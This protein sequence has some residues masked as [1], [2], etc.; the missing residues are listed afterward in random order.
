METLTET[1]RTEEVLSRRSFLRKAAYTAPAVVTLGALTAPV[2]ARA[3]VFTHSTQTNPSTNPATITSE[4]VIYTQDGTNNVINGT[5]T[6]VPYTG[7]ED[8][9]ELSGAQIKTK[10]SAGQA[11]WTW[12]D[13]LFGTPGNWN[14]L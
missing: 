6:D 7:S 8:T 3:S 13:G 4:E 14:G 5:T 1:N 11:K 10:I 12:V 9:T 2:S